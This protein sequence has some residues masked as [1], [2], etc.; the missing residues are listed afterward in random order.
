MSAVTRGL[1]RY[2][3]LAEDNQFSFVCPIFNAQTRITACLKLRELVW[4]GKRPDKRPGCQACMTASKCPV[5]HIV[6]RI[7]A[8][9]Y[10]D[11]YGSSEP[12]LGQLRKDDL[13]RIAPI[14]CDERTIR[15]YPLSDAERLMIASSG[16]RIRKMIS[17]SRNSAPSEELDDTSEIEVVETTPVA[18]RPRPSVTPQ[19]SANDA[20]AKRGD[21]AA[22]INASV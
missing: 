1:K 2:K 14:I 3:T 9:N 12:K 19:A 17:T 21:I 16:E 22:A 4:M 5:V 6:K 20:A 8:D 11:P 15:H 7:G 10:G 18:K 13:E